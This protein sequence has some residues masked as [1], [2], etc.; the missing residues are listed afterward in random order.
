MDMPHHIPQKWKYQY[1]YVPIQNEQTKLP[2]KI[3]QEDLVNEE[4][5]L[6][7]D[8]VKLA[9]VIAENI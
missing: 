3:V 9:K 4:F 5:P 1:K 6:Y 7:H 8:S 2:F